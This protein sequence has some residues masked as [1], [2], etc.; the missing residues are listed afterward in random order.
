MHLS[1]LRQN[2]LGVT[3]ICNKVQRHVT[4]IPGF[5]NGKCGYWIIISQPDGNHQT[6]FIDLAYLP[7]LESAKVMDYKEFP[8]PPGL[9]GDPVEAQPESA[10]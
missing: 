5:R 4:S 10:S 2:T 9:L 7:N 8:L 1:M 3:V 6:T